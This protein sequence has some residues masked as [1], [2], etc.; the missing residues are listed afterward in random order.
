MNENHFDLYGCA[1]PKKLSKFFKKRTGYCLYSKYQ[2]QKH[3]SFWA[4][5]CLYKLYLT[6]VLGK[7]FKSAVLN[8]YYQRFS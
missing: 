8:L 7:D 1:P 6:E 2:I 3:D 5:F 4:S